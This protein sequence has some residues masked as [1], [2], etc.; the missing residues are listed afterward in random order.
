MTREIDSEGGVQTERD[1]QER[2]G[3]DG[4]QITHQENKDAGSETPNDTNN[5]EH[6]PPVDAYDSH[7]HVET[8][9]NSSDPHRPDPWGALTAALTAF[10]QSSPGQ[11]TVEQSETVQSLLDEVRDCLEAIAR[12]PESASEAQDQTVDEILDKLTALQGCCLN[13]CGP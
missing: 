3:S 12:T 11:P 8:E 10:L 1:Q 2:A 13:R 7:E 4:A 9:A 5:S 6:I